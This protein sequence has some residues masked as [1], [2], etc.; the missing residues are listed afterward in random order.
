MV[1]AR[2]LHKSIQT[3][4]AAGEA[5]LEASA[6]IELGRVLASAGEYGPAESSLRRSLDMLEKRGDLS[7][8]ARAYNAI[9]W[10]ILRPQGRLDEALG[11]IHK[12]E[13]LAL[14]Q[15]NLR[16]LAP[17]YHSLGEVWARKGFSEK[18]EEYFHKSLE[19]FERQ[20]DEHGA[21]Y[22]HLGLAIAASARGQYE[23]A[24]EEFGRALALFERVRTPLDIAYA[25]GEFSRMWAQKGDRKKAAACGAR[26]RRMMAALKKTGKPVSR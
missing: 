22:N 19:L 21:A 3:A 13:E 26:S 14:S 25:Y 11:M 12:G 23:R 20:R 17:I 7:E 4:R 2:M 6:G 15:G 1:S 5:D 10:E 16:E 8:T 9:G 18:A 24:A